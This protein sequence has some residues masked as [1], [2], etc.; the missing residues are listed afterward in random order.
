MFMYI[1]II[2]RTIQIL[3]CIEEVGSRSKKVQPSGGFFPSVQTPENVGSEKEKFCNITN[4]RKDLFVCDKIKFYT[5]CIYAVLNKK[6][7]EF[8]TLISAQTNNQ[9]LPY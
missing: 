6:S 7:T 5:A 2:F 3:L 4:T 8:Q 9:S 1:Q